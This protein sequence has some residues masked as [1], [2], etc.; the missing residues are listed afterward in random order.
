M[1]NFLFPRRKELTKKHTSPVSVQKPPFMKKGLHF[2]TFTHFS[3][4]C[5]SFC[6]TASLT[7]ETFQPACWRS[8]S[9][10]ATSWVLLRSLTAH[11]PVLLATLQALLTSELND[12]VLSLL[13]LGGPAE[14]RDTNE[15]E[16][17]GG[18]CGVTFHFVVAWT[19]LFSL[20]W[21][22]SSDSI[23]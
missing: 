23:K 8:G 10:G 20:A 11:S 1:G 7:V 12:G 18:A 22:A 19:S 9:L 13:V 17:G 4:L 15:G 16:G 2:S 3:C 21:L 6:D 14:S 5:S